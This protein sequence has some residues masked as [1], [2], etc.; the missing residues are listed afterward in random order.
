MVHFT[1]NT[2]QMKRKILNSS[3]KIS[4]LFP[5]PE[6]KFIADMTYGML[7]SKSCLFTDVVE[8]LHDPSKKI[9]I[10]DFFQNIW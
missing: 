8:Q 4:R 5:K 1:S 10:G 6:Q 9:N 2:Y 7:T 3:K